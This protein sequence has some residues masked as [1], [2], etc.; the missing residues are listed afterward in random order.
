M[1]DTAEIH[2]GK[3]TPDFL[4]VNEGNFNVLRIGN[5]DV[6]NPSTIMTILFYY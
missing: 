4:E 3:G 1:N 6:T 5:L 2:S